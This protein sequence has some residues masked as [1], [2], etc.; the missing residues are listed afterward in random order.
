MTP[1]KFEIV[2]SAKEF[3]DRFFDPEKSSKLC[4]ACPFFGARWA[5]PP[6]EKSFDPLGFSRV[7]IFA[8][9]AEVEGD[10][11]ASN[12]AARAE[13]DRDML[14]LEAETAGSLAMF[15]GSCANC[16]LDKCPREQNLPCP[17]PESMRI[18]PE[19]AGFD[20]SSLSEELFALKID[21]G[22]DGGAPKT[23]TLVAALF[24]D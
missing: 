6:F 5:C 17:T 11:T 1:Q 20:V 18:S 9:R 22:K 8:R 21:W 23:L 24:F 14:M 3:S 12:A 7:K 10:L 13:F 16:E 4:G 15:A 2:L 19:S